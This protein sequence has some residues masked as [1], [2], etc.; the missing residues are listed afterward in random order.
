[1][2][3]RGRARTRSP[4]YWRAYYTRKQREWRAAH[5][6]AR[7]RRKQ[8]IADWPSVPSHEESLFLRQNDYWIIRY[9]GHAALLKS[10]RGLHYLAVLLH[11]PG[12]EFHVMELLARPLDPSTLAAGAAVHGHVT[13]GLFA[14]VPVLDTQAKAECK[15][16]LNELRQD[17]NEA[18]R[19]NDP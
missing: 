19:F 15:R 2:E 7:R 16:R 5:P 11:D 1:M 13:G 4:E 10:T 6:R 3:K 8:K 12:R 14:G 9:H 18:E 17:L